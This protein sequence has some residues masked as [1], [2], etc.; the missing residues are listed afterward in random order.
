MLLFLLLA[1]GVL[2]GAGSIARVYKGRW[3]GLDVAVK[4]W[5]VLWLLS[6]LSVIRRA[7]C[8]F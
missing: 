8:V 4:V 6:C 5:A 2:L 1:A 7:S 3:S